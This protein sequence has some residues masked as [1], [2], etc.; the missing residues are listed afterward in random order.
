MKKNL[1]QKTEGCRNLVSHIFGRMKVPGIQ[2]KQY[3][4]CYGI[5]QVEVVGAGRVT[6]R[7]DSEE[8]S[9]NSHLMMIA[10]WRG[11]D[12]VQRFHKSLPRFK[13]VHRQI[14]VAIG[15]PNIHHRRRTKFDSE[16]FTDAPAGDAVIDPELPH[17]RIGVTQCR[18]FTQRVRETGRIE[19]Q[20]QLVGLRPLYPLLEMA[21]FN[22]I[23]LDRRVR[24]EIDCV[25]IEPLPACNLRQHHFKIGAQFI[26]IAGTAGIVAAGLDSPC[27][28]SVR[29]LKSADVIALPTVNG[30]GNLIEPLK[31]TRSVHSNGGV[32]FTCQFVS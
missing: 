12:L 11:D 25:E 32:S 23:A 19:V 8:L 29:I 21:R 26:G 2:A 3:L 15:N 28:I 30:D 1:V 14:L 7:A 20:S 24:L 6:L 22:C 27:K 5:S 4:A 10:N 17:Y 16:V 31:G 18:L 9:L 13:A